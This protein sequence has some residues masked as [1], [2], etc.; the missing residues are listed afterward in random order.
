MFGSPPYTDARLYLEAGQDLG[1]S[2]GTDEWVEWMLKVTARSSQGK[3]AETLFGSLRGQPETGITSQ[4][5][6]VLMWEWFKKNRID[7]PG[8]L[9]TGIGLEFWKRWRPMVPGRRRIRHVFKR[10]PVRSVDWTIPPWGIRRNGNRGGKLS[11]RNQERAY[12]AI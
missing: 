4:R 11:C 6:K 8:S 9:A 12:A 5:V 2:R 1:I 7:V 10:P 3:P